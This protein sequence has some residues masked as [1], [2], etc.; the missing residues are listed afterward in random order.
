[1]PSTRPSLVAALLC[2]VAV[3]AWAPDADARK[4][5]DQLNQVTCECECAVRREGREAMIESKTVL[6]PGGDPKQC[7]GFDGVSCRNKR[8]DGTT[9]LGKLEQCSAVVNR[10]GRTKPDAPKGGA[11]KVAPPPRRPPP[12]RPV[13]PPNQRR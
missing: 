13:R 5:K 4:R 10:D 7:G 11:D 3:F 1:M 9:A 6:A 12:K 8:K 2:G